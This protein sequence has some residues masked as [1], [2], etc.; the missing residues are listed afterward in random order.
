MDCF[1]AHLSIN[2]L[3]ITHCNC[4]SLYRQ[5]WFLAL[6]SLRVGHLA[7]KSNKDVNN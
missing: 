1:N 6:L 5:Y 4:N 7:V 3:Y 2:P